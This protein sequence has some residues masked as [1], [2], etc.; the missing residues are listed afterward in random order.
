[1]I[2]CCKNIS[3]SILLRNKKGEVIMIVHESL[4]AP[5]YG[6]SERQIRKFLKSVAF[7][8]REQNAAIGYVHYV[9]SRAHKTSQKYE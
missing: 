1:M 7:T 9:R 6:A 2:T 5:W 4:L 3:Q 8:K